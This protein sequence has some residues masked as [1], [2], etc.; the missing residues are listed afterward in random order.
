MGIR[1]AMIT[2][3]YPPDACG[4]GDYTARLVSCLREAGLEVEVFSDFNW[5]VTGFARLARAIHRFQPDIVH[6]QYPTVGYGKGLL[7]QLLSIVIAPCVVTLHEASQV[8]WLRRLSLYPFA[9]RARRIVMTS[10]FERDYVAKA[11]PWI[12]RRLQVIRIGGFA[13]FSPAQHKDFPE[14]TYFGLIRP[15]KGV[16]AFLQ[17]ARMAQQEGGKLSF[18]VIGQPDAKSMEYYHSLRAQ[19]AGLPVEW[20]I[21]QDAPI[22]ADMLSRT[23]IAYLPFPDGASERRSSLL[24]MLAAG[25]AVV[26]TRGRHTP[27]DMDHAVCFVTSAEEAVHQLS[28]LNADMQQREALVSGA[29]KY[30]ESFSWDKI[31]Y[32]HKSLYEQLV[33]LNK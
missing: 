3:S 21:G 6:V 32:A 17:V 28:W 5:G 31:R 7:P 19:A 2:G 24:A 11:A 33:G 14:V 4:V 30:A 16:E 23:R 29:L 13:V 8:H 15:N 26:T 18:R 9:L 12:R 20:V 22:V 27:A 10:E 1:V 25:V